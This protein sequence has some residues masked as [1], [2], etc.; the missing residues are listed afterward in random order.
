[1]HN[2]YLF[3]NNIRDFVFLLVVVVVVVIFV[4]VTVF[5]TTENLLRYLLEMIR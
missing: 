5:T 4:V 2:F 1:M 3:N